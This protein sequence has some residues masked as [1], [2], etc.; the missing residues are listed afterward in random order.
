MKKR[1]SRHFRST[2]NRST[3]MATVMGITKVGPD[4]T[5]MWQGEDDVWRPAAEHLAHLRALLL[6]IGD[7][8]NPQFCEDYDRKIRG[9]VQSFER[10]IAKGSQ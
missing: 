1:F 9:R 5:Q 8:S 10:E 7:S 3:A 6:T 2:S 4:G